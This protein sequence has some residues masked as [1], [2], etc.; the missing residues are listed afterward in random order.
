MNTSIASKGNSEKK[1]TLSISLL[2]CQ[3]SNSSE[4]TQIAYYPLFEEC[5]KA[6]MKRR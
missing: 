4:T 5:Q 3:S 2:R 1:I 6:T